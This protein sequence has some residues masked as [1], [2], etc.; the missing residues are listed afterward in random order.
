MEEVEGFL[1]RV[2]GVNGVLRWDEQV[3]GVSKYDEQAEGVF[4]F[5][6]WLEGVCSLE[7]QVEGV[8]VV[9]LRVFGNGVEVAIGTGVARELLS[10]LLSGVR[11]LIFKL[12]ANVLH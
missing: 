5:D 12:L 11:V 9:M 7:E 3:E 2:D 10:V 8:L 1:W 6:G 4:C